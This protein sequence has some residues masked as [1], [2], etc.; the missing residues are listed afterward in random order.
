MRKTAV[1]VGAVLICFVF[2]ASSA[3]ADSIRPCSSEV[4]AGGHFASYCGAVSSP[5]ANFDS[6]SS[7]PSFSALD[8]PSFQLESLS[9][10]E[11]RAV[12][13]IFWGEGLGTLRDNE[14]RIHGRGR[15]FDPE[16]FQPQGG[17]S[18][19][20]VTAPEPSSLL[21]ASVGLMGI[22]VFGAGFRRKGPLPP[23]TV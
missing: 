2:V 4:A 6:F 1:V 15:I 5:S 16:P 12:T 17:V 23:G 11:D 13:D 18:P 19:S 10:S 8:E 9:R 14:T 22:A 21:L 20:T 7:S 3:R